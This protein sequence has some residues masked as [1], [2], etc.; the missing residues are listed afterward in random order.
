M[1]LLGRHLVRNAALETLNELELLKIELNRIKKMLLNGH[2]DIQ[3]ESS[4]KVEEKPNGTRDG[5]H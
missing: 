4:I 5:S 3:V 2:H 1:K